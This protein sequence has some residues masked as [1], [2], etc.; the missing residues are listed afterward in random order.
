VIHAKFLGDNPSRLSVLYVKDDCT[1][2]ECAEFKA[3][4]AEARAEFKAS[5]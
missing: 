2:E 1:P 5:A 4:L 3:L